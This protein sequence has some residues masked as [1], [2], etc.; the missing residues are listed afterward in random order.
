MGWS[1]SKT[2][3]LVSSWGLM[4]LHFLTTKWNSYTIT[5][6]LVFIAYISIQLN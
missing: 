4:V 5:T 2:S 1:D 3:L 6:W